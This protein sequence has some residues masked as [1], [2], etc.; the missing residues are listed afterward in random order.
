LGEGERKERR[1]SRVKVRSNGGRTAYAVKRNQKG[2][3]V[4]KKTEPNLLWNSLSLF[5]EKIL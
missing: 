5:D 4:L 2:M 1:A 3:L